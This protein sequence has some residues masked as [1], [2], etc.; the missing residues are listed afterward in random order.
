MEY[1]VIIP[2]F[3]EAESIN[4]L[5]KD[6]HRV[7]ESLSA[8]YEIIYVNDGSR[9]N[10]VQVLNAI[11]PAYPGIKVIS[12]KENSGQSAALHA[13]FIAAQGRW[14]ITLDADGQNPP[15]EILQLI[16]YRD[17]FDFITGIRQQRKDSF[18]RKV[19]SQTAGF[20][21][22]VV[23]RDETRDTGC[24]LR[25][26]K[27]E[28]ATKI[29]FF[30]N[31]HRFFTFLARK[32]KFSVKEVYVSH[33]PRKFGRSKYTTVAR[34]RAGIFDLWGVFWLSRRLFNYEIERN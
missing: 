23:L 11:K 3:N 25:V 26:F 29:P 10:S 24:S 2:L 19:S 27:R 17:D 22:W 30:R 33:Q 13:G 31:F 34:I 16:K 20:F 15:Q 18:F 1:S 6:L 9:D 14:L 5:Q 12:L 7:M 21:R 4:S 32:T 28:I 8:G